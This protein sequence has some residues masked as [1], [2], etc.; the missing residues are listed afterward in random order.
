MFHMLWV[1]GVAEAVP[2]RLTSP[3]LGW[4]GAAALTRLCT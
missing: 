1:D 2:E 4:G 3:V